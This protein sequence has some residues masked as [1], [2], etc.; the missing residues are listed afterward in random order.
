MLLPFSLIFFEFHR[1]LNYYKLSVLA[2]SDMQYH[3]D[4]VH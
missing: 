2:P 1:F 3:W 4:G